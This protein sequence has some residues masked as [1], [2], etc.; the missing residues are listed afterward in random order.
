[1]YAPPILLPTDNIFLVSILLS[2]AGN[3]SLLCEDVPRIGE[4]IFFLCAPA[5]K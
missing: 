2:W 1:M 5:T 3:R 4:I